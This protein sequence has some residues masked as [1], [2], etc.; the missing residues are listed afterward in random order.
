MN[1][2][3][4]PPQQLLAKQCYYQTSWFEREKNSLFD[5]SWGFAAIESSLPNKGD[6]HCFS[7]LH[8]SL[9]VVRNQHGDLEA[10]HNICRHRG[11]EVLEGDGNTGGTIVCPYHKWT[12]N[13]DGSL[14]GVTNL[15]ECFEEIDK[16]KLGLKPAS[17]GIF[18]GMVFVNPSDQPRENFEQWI[19]NLADFDWP[20][21]FNDGNIVYTGEISYEMKCNWKVFYENAID[22]YHLAYLHDQTLGKLFPSKNT[23]EIAGRHHLWYSTERDGKPNATS[24]LSEQFAVQG[25]AEKIYPGDPADYPGVVM[26]FP[27]TLINPTPWGLYISVLEPT[28]AETC[29]LRIYMWAPPGSTGRFDIPPSEKPIAL[30]D[31]DNHPMESGNFQLEDMWIVEKIQRTLHSPEFEVG[32]LANGAGAEAP[33]MHFQQSVLDF[34]DES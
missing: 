11:C 17:V 2:Q 4:K 24:I 21:D 28:S 34:L 27:L 18:K 33:L 16:T 7:F 14:R 32:P 22:G 29:I 20:H 6:Y 3:F 9:L 23:W 31:L 8:H 13:L 15:D 19:A 26:M 12:Y 1:Q 30:S 10:F 5:Q 25:G